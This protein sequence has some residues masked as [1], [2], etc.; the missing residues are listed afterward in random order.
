MYIN[1]EKEV[2][3]KE[4]VTVAVKCDKC[5]LIIEEQDRGYH[6]YVSFGVNPVPS[7]PDDWFAYFQ[8]CNN[9]ADNLLESWLQYHEGH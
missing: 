2:T 1:E 8:L 5:G 7:F 3:R 4:S 6:K 9:C